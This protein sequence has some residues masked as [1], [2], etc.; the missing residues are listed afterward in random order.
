VAN[1]ID[2]WERNFSEAALEDGYQYN[3]YSYGADYSDNNS[4]GAYFS[5]FTFI[6]DMTTPTSKVDFPVHNSF[7]GEGVGSA[8]T[9]TADDSV[10]NIQGWSSPQD[11][12]SG[13][14]ATGVEIAM[15]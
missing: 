7:L 8:I 15:K 6:V 14:N 12:E 9:G 11:F 13:I 4:D 1:N 5:T 10:E 3:L 2:P